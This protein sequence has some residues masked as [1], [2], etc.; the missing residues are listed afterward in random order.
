MNYLFPVFLLIS[1]TACT[2]SREPV[3]QIRT[4]IVIQASPAEVFAVLAD[5]ER[6]PQWNPYHRSVQ[7]EF[8]EGAPL[9]IH[10]L[11]P[12]GEEVDGRTDFWSLGTV[13]YQMVTGRVP[14]PGEN[15]GAVI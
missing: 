5:F 2:N 13:C 1:L 7:G 15:I 4:D 11:R 10:I 6:Y 9:N 12:D 3:I 14:F 8:V